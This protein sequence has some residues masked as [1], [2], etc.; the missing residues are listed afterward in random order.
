M[1]TQ[2]TR[3]AVLT[4]GVA[5]LMKMA[6]DTFFL[7]TFYSISFVESDECTINNI[8]YA[9][10]FIKNEYECYDHALNNKSIVNVPQ[11]L[12]MGNIYLMIYVN[13]N[14]VF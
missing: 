11:T 13:L 12:D 1:G 7:E 5:I 14:Y 10:L 4:W 8:S 2:M 6:Y 3:I 9:S